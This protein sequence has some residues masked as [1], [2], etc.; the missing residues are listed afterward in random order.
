METRHTAVAPLPICLLPRLPLSRYGL[1][2]SISSHHSLLLTFSGFPLHLEN[3]PKGRQ[4]PSWLCSFA[5]PILGC[6]TLNNLM[7][8]SRPLPVFKWTIPMITL[9]LPSAHFLPKGHVTATSHPS[10]LDLKLTL[11]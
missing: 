5:N 7:P 10:G 6:S 9:G 8:T 4:G 2:T 11:S 1:T 3:N